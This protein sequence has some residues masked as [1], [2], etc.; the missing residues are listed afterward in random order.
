MVNMYNEVVKRQEYPDGLKVPMHAYY[1][2]LMPDFP[3]RKAP[4]LTDQALAE[5]LDHECF[6]MVVVMVWCD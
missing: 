4:K 5:A 2:D 6:D 1:G 3:S